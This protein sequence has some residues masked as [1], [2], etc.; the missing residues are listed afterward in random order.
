[1]FQKALLREYLMRCSA[2]TWLREVNKA[3]LNVIS[4]LIFLARTRQEGSRRAG[5]AALRL[6]MRFTKRS[7]GMPLGV[8][9]ID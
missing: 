5:A 7:L 8:Q 1:M 9:V 2:L 4:S 3:C 6:R